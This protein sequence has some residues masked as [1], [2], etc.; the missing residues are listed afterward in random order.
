MKLLMLL[1]GLSVKHMKRHIKYSKLVFCILF[2]YICST[3]G[4]ET[5]S[6]PVC[7]P[8][9]VSP[10]QMLCQLRNAV[11]DDPAVPFAKLPIRFLVVHAFPRC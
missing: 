9:C 7:S 8:S 6:L 1:L 3:N 10:V 4:A 5:P 2:I 11:V